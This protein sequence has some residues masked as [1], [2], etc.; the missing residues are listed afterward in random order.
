VKKP[1]EIPESE[2]AKEAQVKKQIGQTEAKIEETRDLITGVN[3][4]FEKANGEVEKAIAG[5]KEMRNAAKKARQRAKNLSDV[6][7]DNEANQEAVEK[8]END[9]KKA[10]GMKAKAIA[11]RDAFAGEINSL[12]MVLGKQLQALEGLKKH[13]N[14]TQ[15]VKPENPKK[16]K[17]ESEDVMHEGIPNLILNFYKTL[18][19]K[20]PWARKNFMVHAIKE[21]MKLYRC[22]EKEAIKNQILFTMNGC[23]NKEFLKILEDALV[24]IEGEAKSATP[25]VK[26]TVVPSVPVVQVVPDSSAFPGLSSTQA[27]P[28]TTTVQKEWAEN[29]AKSREKVKATHT[30]NPKAAAKTQATATSKTQA[31]ATSKT[32]ATPS[33]STTEA[34]KAK[35]IAGIIRDLMETGFTREMAF[36]IALNLV[37]Q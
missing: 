3:A 10:S 22:T 30:T 16:P 28:T 13:L 25:I 17:V 15:G 32:Q 2:E 31:T 21:T 1:F 20:N 9:V 26:K 33:P 7:S 11:N 5:L 18:G 23:M 19:V 34:T 4:L 36:G 14:K 12:K 8:A 6:D 24:E 29:A 27:T 35:E 37:S